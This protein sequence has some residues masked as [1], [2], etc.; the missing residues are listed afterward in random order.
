MRLLIQNLTFGYDYR[1]VLK[2]ISLKINSGDFLAVIGN[3]G[4]GKSTLIKCILG[5]NKVAPGQIFL[6]DIDV[7]LFTNFINIGYVP[8]KF[9]DFN[10][11][12]PITVNEILSASNVRDI[13]EDKLLEL[14][15]KSGILELQNENIN[16]LSGGQ[17]QRVFIVRSLMNDPKML[18][19]DE[20][21]VGVDRKN[22]EAFYKLVNELNAGGITI[23]LI[24]HNIHESKANLSHV[25]SIHNGEGVF[26]EVERGEDE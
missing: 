25:L 14:L 15:D 7:S 8:Q 1:T 5:I 10:Y 16:N 12:F 23:I 2:D 6:D 24:T 17:L 20:P 26:R 21:T 18:I 11:E 3:N 19:L 22:V 13:S 9:D 4:A